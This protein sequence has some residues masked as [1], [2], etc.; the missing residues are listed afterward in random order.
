MAKQILIVFKP[1]VKP[2]I[3]Y[4]PSVQMP[5]P[6]QTGKFL[7]PEL[8]EIDVEGLEDPL[9]AF[10]LPDVAARRVLAA[11]PH[12]WKY[13]GVR[14]TEDAEWS[15]DTLKGVMAPSRYG[16]SEAIDIES[17]QG[18]IKAQALVQA[19]AAKAKA[20]AATSAAAAAA[21]SAATGGK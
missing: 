18:S 19:K 17:I 1:D 2:P 6:Y 12:V 21:A 14:K 10:A 9:Y 4:I 20:S 7:I 5:D 16:T 3:G 8:E 13:W 11:E 15:D